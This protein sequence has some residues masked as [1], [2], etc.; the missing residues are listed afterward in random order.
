MTPTLFKNS[1]L[2]IKLS[3]SAL[4]DRMGLSLSAIQKIEASNQPVKKT[5]ELSLRFIAKEEFSL[6]LPLEHQE[7][8]L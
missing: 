4:A 5:N 2:K 6:I 1:R 7:E 8:L 3:Q